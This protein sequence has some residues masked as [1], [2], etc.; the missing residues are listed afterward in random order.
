VISARR[1]INW[2]T[3]IACFAASTHPPRGNCGR[4]VSVARRFGKSDGGIDYGRLDSR[5]RSR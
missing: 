1:V 5:L 3:K 2:F 4:A